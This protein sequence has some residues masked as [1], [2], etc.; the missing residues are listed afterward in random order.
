MSL[1][2][3]KNRQTGLLGFIVIFLFLVYLPDA[4][5]ICAWSTFSHY[6]NAVFDYSN[7]GTMDSKISSTYGEESR[8]LQSRNRW[9]D[10]WFPY[11]HISILSKMRQLPCKKIVMHHIMPYTALFLVIIGYIFR[12][13]GKKRHKAFLYTNKNLKEEKVWVRE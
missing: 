7:I 12:T 11:C 8:F 4:Q 13:D 10:K 1:G 5:E 3:E 2:W 6:G 9:D